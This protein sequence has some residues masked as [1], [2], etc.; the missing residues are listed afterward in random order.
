VINDG[1]LTLGD[2][3][4]M[5]L[6]TNPFPI[7][8]V[9]LEHKKIRVCTDQAKTTKGKNVVVSEDL[10]NWMIRPHNPEIG[11]WKENVQRKLAKRVKPT[12]V[13]LIGKYQRQLEEDRRY[14]VTQGIKRD[15]FFDA[16]NR[17]SW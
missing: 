5:K 4:K 1:R 15:R 6:D 16:Q 2:G 14:R 7:S 17:H 9:E 12:S 11:M 10:R 13:M 8:M 3:G